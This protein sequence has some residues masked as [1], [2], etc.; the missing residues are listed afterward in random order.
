MTPAATRVSTT[1]RRSPTITTS[2]PA[3]IAT[4]QTC[5]RA[6]SEGDGGAGDGT[7]GGWTSASE[8]RSRDAVGSERA[9]VPGAEQDEREGRRERDER[10]QQRAADPRCGVPDDGN[11]LDDG[12]GVICPSATALRNWVFVIQW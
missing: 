11:G 7:D 10:R 12:P 4:C 2:A 6:E 3:R 1:L 5:A 9:E 8:E